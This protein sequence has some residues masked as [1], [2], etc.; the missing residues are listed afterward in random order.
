M[1]ITVCI[2]FTKR[3]SFFLWYTP[4]ANILG[5]WES[6]YFVQLLTG[7]YVLSNKSLLFLTIKIVHISGVSAEPLIC[8]W[9]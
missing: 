1:D 9:K 8:C 2:D 7:S 5:T 4:S 6:D 3:N